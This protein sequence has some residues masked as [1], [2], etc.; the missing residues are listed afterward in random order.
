M[1][2]T[3]KSNNESEEYKLISF[4]QGII[5]DKALNML[6]L[7]NNGIGFEICV[8][9]FC[10]DRIGEIG[11]KA[12]VYTYIYVREDEISLYGFYDK[13]EKEV[14][15]KLLLVNGVGPK[16]AINIL[17][18][19]SAEDLSFAIATQ[20]ISV[21]KNIKGVGAK[22][23]ER[24]MLELKEKMDA[25]SHLASVSL[26]E[27]EANDSEAYTATLN[28]LMDWGVPRVHAQDV[29]NKVF[30]STDDMESLLA[31]AFRELGK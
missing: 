9:K 6:T 22:L 7:E 17:S 27:M 28:V 14:F 13:F 5:A 15:C 11:A 3:N 19:V 21:L 20:N 24:I 4:L 30:E 25:L 12:T 29:L 18:G 31:K 2:F 26:T 16:M 10:L 8:S 23:R 1:S